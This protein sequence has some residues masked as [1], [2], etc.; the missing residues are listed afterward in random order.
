M[1]TPYIAAHTQMLP[2]IEGTVNM[3]C[4][5]KIYRQVT[6]IYKQTKIDGIVQESCHNI[7]YQATYTIVH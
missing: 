3:V 5:N 4:G 6:L 7:G 1:I 2:V